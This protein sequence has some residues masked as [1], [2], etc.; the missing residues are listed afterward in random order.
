MKVPEVRRVVVIPIIV[1]VVKI[2]R[3]TFQSRAFLN[4]DSTFDRIELNI[5]PGKLECSMREKPEIFAKN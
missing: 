1:V 2:K 5:E 4:N 3:M